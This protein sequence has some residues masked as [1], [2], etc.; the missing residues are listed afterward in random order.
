MKKALLLIFILGI[1]IRCTTDSI[2]LK[3]CS[4]PA[5]V[6]DLTGVDGCGWVFELNDGTIVNPQIIMRCG[7]PPLPQEVTEDPLFNFQWADGK[8]VLISYEDVEGASIC[9]AGKLVKIT[10]IQEAD[11]ISDCIL[12][13]IEEIKNEPVW[14][15]PAVVYQ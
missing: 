5:T 3:D 13:K 8:R 14:N 2:S 1:F 9:M 7:T 15:P 11:P 12:A 6:K 10:C 4:T